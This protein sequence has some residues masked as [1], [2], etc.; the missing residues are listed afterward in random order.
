MLENLNGIALLGLAEIEN[1]IV[2]NK[3]ITSP[4]LK[5]YHYKFIHFDSKDFDLV[6]KIKLLGSI[7]I[8]IR[9]KEFLAFFRPANECNVPLIL[10]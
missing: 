2:L 10:R 1:K 9:T 6:I 5:K 4:L 3:L 8:R 7:L